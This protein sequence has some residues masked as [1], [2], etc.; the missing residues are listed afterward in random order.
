ML[1]PQCW[2]AQSVITFRVRT[3]K[4]V[5]KD[6]IDRTL[7]VSSPTPSTNPFYSQRPQRNSEAQAVTT[8]NGPREILADQK[9]FQKTQTATTRIGSRDKNTH[10]TNWRK[11]WVDINAR[12][13][14]TT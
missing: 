8:Q 11:R 7:Q 4:E 5:I 6:H 10:S 1:R 9:Q 2:R 13:H 12:I 14:S 3:F